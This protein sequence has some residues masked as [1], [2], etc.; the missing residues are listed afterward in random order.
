MIITV[1]ESAD[2]RSVE[3]QLIARGLWID[4]FEGAGRAQVLVHTGSRAV[5]RGELLTIDGVES[6][7]ER[8][9]AHPKVDA[10]GPV[11]RIGAME[12]GLGREPAHIAG[13][14]SVESEAQIRS[15]ARIVSRFGVRL[16]RGGAFKPRS[17]PRAFQGHG[18]AALSWMRRAADEHG[19]FVVTEAMS[20]EQAELVARYADVIQ[21]GSRTMH[22]SALL[23]A[24]GAHRKPILLKRGMAATIEEWLS[25]AEYALEAGAPSVVFC[26]RG[27]RSFDPST[28]NLLDLGAVA[29]LA[30]VLHQPV[31][32]DPSH[33]LGRR[34]LMGPIARAAMAS[35]ACG[36][37]LETHEDPGSALSDG[38]QA[39]LPVELERVLAEVKHANG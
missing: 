11:V 14:C 31:L 19:L 38:P 22:D 15:I 7:S 2:V 32:V 21:I 27:V 13:P 33:A 3:R 5:D 8:K 26:E 16:L 35:G 12:I 37:M 18:E 34:D 30:H 10:Q 17:S 1:A 23:K 4:R 39:L 28:R 9:S 24:A 20:A 29:L 25:A 36:L 6:V